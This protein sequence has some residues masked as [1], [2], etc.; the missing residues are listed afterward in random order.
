MS[1]ALRT[2]SLAIVTALALSGC[3]KMEMNY[4]LNEDDTVDGSIVM[5]IEKGVGESMGMSDEDLLAE[6]GT[7]ESFDDIEGGTVEAYD[8]G[9]YVGTKVT[10]EGEP[11]ASLEE[12]DAG[13]TIVR[14]GDEYVVGGTFDTGEEDMSMLTGA[15]MTLAVTFPGAIADS[16]GTVEGNT[17]T[18]DLLDA[19]DELMARG[20]ATA[21]GSGL[22]VW[23]WGVLGAVVLAAV[24]GAV[25]IVTRRNAPATVGSAPVEG[26]VEAPP[27]PEAASFAPP[28][29]DD[30][31][32][33]FAPPAPPAPAEEAPADAEVK[34]EEEV[35]PTTE[36]PAAPDTI[37][38]GSVEG[39]DPEEDHGR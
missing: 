38:L 23:I 28:A 33:G 12:Q 20:S 15:T 22:P 21:G 7:E 29:A 14:D 9:D 30:A 31:A 8:D 27:A 2:A 1:K 3:L 6:M 10:F 34:P 11:L 19:P 25:I 37:E 17:V 18:W 13:I 16:N 5:A 39:T 36:L 26:V 4:T 32:E 35:A 24:A